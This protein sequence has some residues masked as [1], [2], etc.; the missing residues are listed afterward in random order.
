MIISQNYFFAYILQ[1][2][3]REEETP[4]SLALAVLFLTLFLSVWQVFCFAL[5]LVKKETLVCVSANL[6]LERGL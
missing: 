6:A 1:V 4:P 5:N 2:F 3:L